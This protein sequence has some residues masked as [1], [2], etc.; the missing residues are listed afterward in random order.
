ML[1]MNFG[2]VIEDSP[3]YTHSHFGAYNAVDTIPLSSVYLG[4]CQM[5]LTNTVM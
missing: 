2:T 5:S 4:K 3:S 1:L